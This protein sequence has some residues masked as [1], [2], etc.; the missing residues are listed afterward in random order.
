M[1]EAETQFK[2]TKQDDGSVLLEHAG[3][4]SFTLTSD[5]AYALLDFLYKM[6]DDLAST[7]HQEDRQHIVHEFER[8]DQLAELPAA[9]VSE[10]LPEC[11]TNW[12]AV[13]RLPRFNP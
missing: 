2:V 11:A 8:T 1:Q 12:A 13:S 10:L 9:G 3:A 5:E 4:D 6:R 7:V